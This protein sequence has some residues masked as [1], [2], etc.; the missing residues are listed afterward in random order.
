MNKY[1]WDLVNVMNSAVGKASRENFEKGI[2]EGVARV[3]RA[4]K[5]KG[6]SPEIISETTGL[7]IEE[8]ANL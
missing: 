7:T 2:E 8:L 4:L 6:I 1:Y 3:A 5:L